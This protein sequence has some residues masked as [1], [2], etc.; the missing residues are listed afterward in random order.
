MKNIF[1]SISSF[2]KKILNP[3]KSFDIAM[4]C[5]DPEFLEWCFGEKYWKLNDLEK[6]DAWNIKHGHLVILKPLDDVTL[7]FC[8]MG[9]FWL[10]SQKTIASANEMND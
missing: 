3:K 2:F 1:K 7:S 6:I 9:L 5:N 10:E 8:K 4:D